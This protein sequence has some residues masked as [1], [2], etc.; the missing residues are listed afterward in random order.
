MNPKTRQTYIGV[1]GILIV[2]GMAML[3]GFNGRVALSSLGAITS[4][5]GSHVWDD[6]GFTVRKE[7]E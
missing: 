7:A 2:F 1:V 6:I 3:E 4:I 5:V